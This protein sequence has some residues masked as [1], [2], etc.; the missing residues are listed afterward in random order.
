MLIRIAEYIRVGL[1]E[2][3]ERSNW[4]GIY[5]EV[6]EFTLV[7]YAEIVNCSTIFLRPISDTRKILFTWFIV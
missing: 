3:W 7:Y 6:S 5:G 4:Y 1:L 2:K